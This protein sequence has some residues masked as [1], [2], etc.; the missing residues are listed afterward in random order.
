MENREIVNTLG[1]EDK[2]K[3]FMLCDNMIQRQR[4]ILETATSPQEVFTSQGAIRILR[5]IQKLMQKKG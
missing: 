2:I 4:D 1:E 5:D 3:I